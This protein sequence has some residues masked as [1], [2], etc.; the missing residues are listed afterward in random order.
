M[1]LIDFPQGTPE[2]LSARVGVPSGSKFADIMASGKGG[3]PSVT[4][5]S[6]LT[7]IALEI[8][9]GVREEFPATPAMVH[10]TEME[11]FAR[12]MYESRTGEM[13]D[14]IGFC[15]HDTINCGVSPDGLVNHNGLTEYKCPQPKTHLEYLRRA[16]APPAY[17]W[18]IMGQ[19]WVMER[20][21]NDFVS[22]SPAF[23]DNAKI[24]IRRVYRDEAAIKLLEAEV[25][26][27]LEEVEQEVEFIR[28]YKEAA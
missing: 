2:W 7:A 11:P 16:D 27:F 15:L 23:P 9:T 21:W 1:R 17:K 5:Q 3:A 19:L 20:E 28:T 8:V 24:A 12:A 6:Y 10:G 14:E 26:K 22:Y 13:V 18:Q 4:R 25:R